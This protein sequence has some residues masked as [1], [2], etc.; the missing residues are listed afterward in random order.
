MIEIHHERAFGR[1]PLKE[2]QVELVLSMRGERHLR[3]LCASLRAAG[4]EAVL[5]DA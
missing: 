3:D 2:A 4:Y 1:V 5:P